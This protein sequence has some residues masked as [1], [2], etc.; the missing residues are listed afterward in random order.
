[1][2]TI[3]HSGFVYRGLPV[4]PGQLDAAVLRA[5]MDKQYSK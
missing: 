4:V 5:G 3:T 2:I 1:V